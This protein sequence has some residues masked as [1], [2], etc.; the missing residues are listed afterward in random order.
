MYQA[1]AAGRNG[2]RFFEPDMQTAVS[3]AAQ[4]H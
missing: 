2:L 3:A 4:A 1:K